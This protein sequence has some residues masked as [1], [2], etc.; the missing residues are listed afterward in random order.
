MLIVLAK[1]IM[2]KNVIS[3][4]PE[5]SI[6]E[7]AELLLAERISGVPVVDD[8]GTLCGIVS[9]SDLMRKEIA[10]EMPDELCILGAVIYYNGLQEYRDAF[11]KFAAMTAQEIMTEKVLTVKVNDD[12][13]RVAKLMLD[14]HIKR[15]PVMDGDKLA[16]IVSR[17]D[18]VKMLL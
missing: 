3:V 13:S 7:L 5:A 10:P 12:V 15:L 16:G 2:T 9:E 14:K 6:R 11:R 17:S 1:E 4:K 8:A 18:I